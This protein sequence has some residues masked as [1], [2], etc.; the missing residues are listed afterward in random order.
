MLNAAREIKVMQKQRQKWHAQL[1]KVLADSG[2]YMPARSTAAPTMPQS[3]ELHTSRSAP[4]SPRSASAKEYH[5]VA[6]QVKAFNKTPA[7]FRSRA[8]G[9]PPP[10][11]VDPPRGN[12]PPPPQGP[13]APRVTKSGDPV[14]D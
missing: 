13:S 7:R 12:L 9:A 2:T 3:P 5:P 1:N 6:E 14:P 4:T 10:T 8:A 11:P